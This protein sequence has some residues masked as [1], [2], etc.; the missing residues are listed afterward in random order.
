MK[1]FKNYENKTLVESGQRGKW[2]IK[3]LVQ[4]ILGLKKIFVKKT[5][6][7]EKFWANILVKLGQFQ[8][9]YY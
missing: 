6:V 7:F 4:R 3:I 2:S 8:M 5:F 1:K 9:K